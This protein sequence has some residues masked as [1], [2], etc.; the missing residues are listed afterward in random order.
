MNKYR[1]YLST[2]LESSIYYSKNLISMVYLKNINNLKVT[3]FFN[4]KI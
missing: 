1:N 2:D 4:F 3:L